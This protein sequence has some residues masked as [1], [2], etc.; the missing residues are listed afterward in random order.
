MW[1][2]SVESMILNILAL[3]V[4]II[5]CGSI[6]AFIRSILLFIFSQW[7]PE[8][9]KK[10][11]NWIRFMIIGV[12]MT[13][14]LLFFFPLLFKY[15]GVQGYDNYTAKNIFER[16]SEIFTRILNLRSELEEVNQAN[17][18][19]LFENSSQPLRTEPQIE[20]SN[21]EL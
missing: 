9:R 21:Y 5:F 13:I 2:T 8:S 17:D 1:F 20:S 15:M 16:V 19:A 7:D 6:Y 3:L 14:V 4:I 12:I 10:A 11:R 18:G